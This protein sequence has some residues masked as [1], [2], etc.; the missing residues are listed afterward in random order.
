MNFAVKIHVYEIHNPTKHPNLALIKF[1]NIFLTLHTNKRKICPGN[2][3]KKI[4]TICANNF[5]ENL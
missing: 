5:K 1:Y 4:P 2:Q 3:H